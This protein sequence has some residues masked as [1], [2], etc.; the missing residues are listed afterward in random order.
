M[1]LK[2]YNQKNVVVPEETLEKM[3]NYIVTVLRS[4]LDSQMNQKINDFISYCN[5]HDKKQYLEGIKDARRTVTM[6]LSEE[7]YDAILNG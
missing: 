2:Y 4:P 1:L 5:L 7:D 6:N 3:Q